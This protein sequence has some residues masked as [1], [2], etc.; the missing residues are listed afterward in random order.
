MASPS[1]SQ[2]LKRMVEATVDILMDQIASGEI[3]AEHRILNGDLVVRTS[4]RLPKTRHRR[5]ST[6]S[7]IYRPEGDVMHAPSPTT[8]AAGFAR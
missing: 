8:A 4:A 6:A 5:A 3:E 2:P 7:S 1:M